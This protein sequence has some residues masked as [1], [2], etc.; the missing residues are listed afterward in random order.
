M[1]VH[2][3]HCARATLCQ[4]TNCPTPL[5]M[6]ATVCHT[7]SV[8]GG[9]PTHMKLLTAI[10]A[11]VL[12]AVPA[13]ATPERTII[14]PT[15]QMITVPGLEFLGAS[16]ISTVEFCAEIEYIADYN[17]II[18]DEELLNMEECLIEHT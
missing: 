17:N 9:K 6:G 8:L 12:A 2:P 4:L 13:S 14:N 3:Y 15:E 1:G 16:R 7:M 18:T 5:D 11:V 10:A